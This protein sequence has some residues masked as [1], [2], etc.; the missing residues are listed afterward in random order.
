[1]LLKKQYVDIEKQGFFERTEAI[2]AGVSQDPE[3]L[4]LVLGILIQ[5]ANKNI[6]RF[7]KFE[8]VFQRIVRTISIIYSANPQT[9]SSDL[10]FIQ[11]LV[12]FREN[13]LLKKSEQLQAIFEEI[14]ESC[15]AQRGHD[16]ET[17]YLSALTALEERKSERRSEKTKLA[18]SDPVKYQEMK[19]QKLRSV[20][21][22]RKQKVIDAKYSS[23]KVKFV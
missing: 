5:I 8:K 14:Y 9:L 3:L 7:K 22:R 11:F 4:S 2:F 6:Q 23:K 15:K 18:I 19:R 21:K 17:D 10:P 13:A 20:S 16:F 12:K 1:M